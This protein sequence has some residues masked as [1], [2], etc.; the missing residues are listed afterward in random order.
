MH[1]REGS[2]STVVSHLN[3]SSSSAVIFLSLSQN[4]LILSLLGIF[5][6]TIFPIILLLCAR[7]AQLNGLKPFMNTPAYPLCPSFPPEFPE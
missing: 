7:P 4:V 5:V 6:F 1:P 3:P 2:A